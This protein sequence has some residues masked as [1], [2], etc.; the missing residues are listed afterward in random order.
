LPQGRA[1][2]RE[3]IGQLRALPGVQSVTVMEERIGGWWSDNSDMLVD[4]KLPQ[5]ANGGSRTVRSNVVGADFFTTL[6]VPVLAGRDFADSDTAASP[7]VGIVNEEF[8]KR[9]LPNENALGHIIG[10]DDGRYSMTIVGVVKNHKYRSIDEEPIPM[11]W[12]E[13]AQIPMVGKM[14][15]EM[16][17][18]GEPLAILPSARKAVQGLD[19]NLALIQPMT[20][21]AQYDL[22]IS[23]EIL[24]ARLAGFFGILAVSLVA[25]GLYGA[26][27]YRVN[28]R[29]AEIGVRMALGARRGQVVW[30][31]LR[32]SLVL[33]AAGV[34]IGIPLSMVLGNVLSSTLYG[35]KPLDGASYLFAVSGIVFV[36]LGASAVPA[37]RAAS[38]EPLTALRAE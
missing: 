5:E 2:Y 32:G 4:G 14:D 12:Y 8:A 7:H 26:L 25:T 37:S 23:N 20:Q 38:V 22:T 1:F 15:V 30:M 6:G 31:I 11:A 34:V 27:S 36:A 10:T 13:Y 18:E 9:F 21:R 3:L 29:K 33:T 28:M 19:P 16:R 24:F 35:V 17:V